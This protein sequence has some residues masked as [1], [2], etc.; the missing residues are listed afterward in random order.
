MSGWTDDLIA[1][2]EKAWNDG[3]SASQIS[4]VLFREH[5]VYFTRNAVIGIIHRRGLTKRGRQAAAVPRHTPATPRRTPARVIIVREARPQAKVFGET[6][7]TPAIVRPFG[8]S[9]PLPGSLDTIDAQCC[10][11][12]ELTDRRCKWPIGSPDLDSFRFCG[13]DV[14]GARAD[15]AARYCATHAARAYQP[16]KTRNG[17]VDLARSLRRYV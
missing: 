10:V 4:A 15:R 16:V 12:T 11:L 17:V 13:R 5:R 14:E 8:P 3:L 9:A 7:V 2:V 6:K 1:C